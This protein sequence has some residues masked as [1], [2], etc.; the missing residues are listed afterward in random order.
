[1]RGLPGSGKSTLAREIAER[2]DGAVIISTDDFFVNAEGEYVFDRE[3]LG[4]Y[5]VSNQRRCK[6]LMDARCPTVII[7]N[8]NTT[9]VEM[10]PYVDLALHYDYTVITTIPDTEWAF[11]VDECAARNTHGVSRDTIQRMLERFEYHVKF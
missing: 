6:A 10:Q 5:H 1:M 3:N 11:D 2:N 7:D 9:R 4:L 8:T